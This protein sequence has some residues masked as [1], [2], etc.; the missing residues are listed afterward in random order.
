MCATR[1]PYGAAFAEYR[2]F[3]SLLDGLFNLRKES[4]SRNEDDDY[5]DLEDD[6]EVDD[7]YW[8]DDYNVDD[9]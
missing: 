8:E 2:A 4:E 7:D 9:D 6:E 3:Q 5:E 1:E